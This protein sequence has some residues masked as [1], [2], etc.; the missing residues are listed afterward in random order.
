MLDNILQFDKELFLIINNSGIGFL[1]SF[2]VFISNTF[3]AIPFFIWIVFSSIKKYGKSFW[4]SILLITLVVGLTDFISVNCFK[5]VFLRFRPSHTPELLEQ[6]H[7]L[8][9]KGG[10]YG[11][12]SSHAANFFAL[13]AIFSTLFSEQVKFIY[14]FYLWAS[15][16]AISRIFVGKHYPLDVFCGALLGIIIAK[17]VWYIIFKTKLKELL[18]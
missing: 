7:L 12:V 13:A 8:V 6:I 9:P 1:D 5:N 11:F 16:V 17:L 10:L 2:W 4:L 18:I 14:I 15:L 3:S